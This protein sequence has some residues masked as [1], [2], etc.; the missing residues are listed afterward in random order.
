MEKLLKT[1]SNLKKI[2]EYYTPKCYD[3]LDGSNR[4]TLAMHAGYTDENIDGFDESIVYMNQIL[5]DFIEIDHNDYILD[6]GCGV[7]GSS[8]WLAKHRNAK[9]IGISI[10]PL[11][12]D[13]AKKF[14][15]QEQLT[16]SQINF[17]VSDYTATGFRDASFDVVWA[18]E[19]VCY[20]G[21]KD[22]F[23]NEAYRLLKPGGRLIVADG[24]VASQ[25]MNKEDRELVESWLDAWMVPNLSTPEQFFGYL[26]DKGFEQIHY[27]DIT[28]NVLPFSVRLYISAAES[29]VQKSGVENI[30]KLSDNYLNEICGAR[31][32]MRS[33][34]GGLWKYAIFSAI[35]PI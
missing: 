31:N 12:M 14:S 24:F 13:F 21:D 22:D 32:Q 28:K 26:R 19:S 23:V 16:S 35:K 7:G 30:A 1:S 2:I 4:A 6:A 34:A 10:V 20:S 18:L 33:L 29:Q 9:V 17:M 5:A 25:D 8:I 11:Q 15:D 3:F 27:R